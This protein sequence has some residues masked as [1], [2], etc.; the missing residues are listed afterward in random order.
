MP[1]FGSQYVTMPVLPLMVTI[2][3]STSALEA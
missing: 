2:W 1:N 3:P